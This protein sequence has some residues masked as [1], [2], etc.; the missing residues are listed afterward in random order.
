MSKVEEFLKNNKRPKSGLTHSIQDDNSYFSELAEEDMD[1]QGKGAP[2]GESNIMVAVRVRPVSQAEEKKG[3]ESI[4]KVMDEKFVTVQDPNNNQGKDDFATNKPSGGVREKQYAFDYAFDENTEQK[5]VFDKTTQFLVDGILDGYNATV[6]AYGATG[7]GKT[8]TMLGKPGNQGI[9]GYAFEELFSHVEQQA[10]EKEFKIKMSFI[11]IYNEMIF[12]LLL[13]NEKPLELRED[14]TKGIHVA[15]IS[16]IRAESTKEVLELLYLGNQ[17]RSTEATDANDESSRS[18]ALLLVTVEHKEKGSEAEDEVKYGKFSLI[19]L[20]GSERAANT[21][22]T[23]IRLVE[24]ANINRSLLALGNCI[25]LLYQ[26]NERKTK[27]YVPFRDSKLTRLLK[28]SLGGNS[29][30]VMIANVSP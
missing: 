24:G 15:G 2:N 1:N 17:N 27:K 19:D 18:H 5:T 30:T 25:T 20:A 28:D 13:P 12:D 14:A 3:L 16:E 8:F 11:E 6:F 26:N 22:N 23:G 21:N 10:Q 29:R 9:F 4:V 7:A